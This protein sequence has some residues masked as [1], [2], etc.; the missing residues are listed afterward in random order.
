MLNLLEIG[1]A[2][3]TCFGGREP[4]RDPIGIVN[5]GLFLLVIGAVYTINPNIISEVIAWFRFLTETRMVVRPPITLINSAAIFFGLIGISNF[6]TAGIRIMVDK[7]WRRILPDV[8]TGI[9]LMSFAYLINQYGRHTITWVQ[10]LG[11]EAVV[12]GIL[13]IIYAVFR[14]LF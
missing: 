4:R 11:S 8:L 2:P 9:G 14:S 1:T 7:V 10:V 3:K 5:L 6:I 12:F 13:V